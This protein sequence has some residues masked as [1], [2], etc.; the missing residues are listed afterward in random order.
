VTRTVILSVG[1]LGL[2]LGL[3]GLRLLG[4]RLEGRTVLDLVKGVVAALV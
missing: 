1:V 4:P 3:L 2:R